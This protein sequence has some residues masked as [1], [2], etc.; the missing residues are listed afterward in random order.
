M[1]ARF[2]PL[3]AS[4]FRSL[5]V[6]GRFIGGHGAEEI[7]WTELDD[8]VA[9]SGQTTIQSEYVFVVAADPHDSTQFNFWTNIYDCHDGNA[10]REFFTTAFAA[11][12]AGKPF[13]Q[14]FTVTPACEN[15]YLKSATVTCALSAQ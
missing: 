15:G 13:Q 11:P 6:C 4:F 9:G 8:S 12:L 3:F 10:Y 1:L 2:S 14:T 7:L 5:G